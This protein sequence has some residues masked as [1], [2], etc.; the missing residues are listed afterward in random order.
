MSDPAA[1]IAERVRRLG[2]LQTEP[3][4]SPSGWKA[5]GRF[6][7][8]FVRVPV[9][10]RFLMTALAVGA[11]ALPAATAQAQPVRDRLAAA[12]RM[13]DFGRAEYDYIARVGPVGQAALQS[14]QVAR[15]RAED[16]RVRSFAESEVM[17]QETLSTI[18]MEVSRDSG[19]PMPAPRPDP[20]MAR[21]LAMLERER[22]NRFDDAYTRMQLQGH[23]EL[24]RIQDDYLR[25]G[26]NA[27]MRH[28]AMLA[29]GQIM[30]HIKALEMLERR[31]ERQDYRRDPYRR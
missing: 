4:R 22:G 17:E 15:S 10:T 27:H 12:A 31:D 6:D 3:V 8:A 23:Q 2:R 28:I 25:S 1:V 13:M 21:E 7:G 24:L 20:R 30:D 29:R 9:K 18:L 16:P 26:R 5:T 11:F 19:R 14:S